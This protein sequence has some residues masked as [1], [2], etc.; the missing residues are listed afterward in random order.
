MC[1]YHQNWP[2]W[3]VTNNKLNALYLNSYQIF[4]QR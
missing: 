1:A 4:R 3:T 2:F